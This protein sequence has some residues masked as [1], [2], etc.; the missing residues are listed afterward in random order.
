MTPELES[1]ILSRLENLERE[2]RALKSPEPAGDA[3]EVVKEK[4]IALITSLNER[5]LESLVREIPY[6]D[7]ATIFFG[8]SRP[9]L[10]KLKA[11][12]SKRRWQELTISWS[13]HL[14]R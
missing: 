7:V 4:M 11:S 12:L 2:I 10:E 3:P 8:L 5:Q 13:Q 9:I 6:D 14:Q 1:Q